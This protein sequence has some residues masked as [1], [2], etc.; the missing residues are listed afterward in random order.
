[1]LEIG[2]S[3]LLKGCVLDNDEYLVEDEVYSYKYQEVFDG[4]TTH[5]LNFIS[6]FGDNEFIDKEEFAIYYINN[7]SEKEILYLNI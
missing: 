3:L 7:R 4:E 2:D 5:K 6:P 1:E